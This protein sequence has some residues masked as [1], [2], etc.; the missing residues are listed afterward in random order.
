MKKLGKSLLI[1]MIGTSILLQSGCF[2]S[3]SL[4]KSVYDWNSSVDDKFTRSLLFW[5]LCIVPVYEIAA[6]VDAVI[7]NVVE[8]WTGSNP[9][10]MKDGER[11]EQ[12]VQVKGKSYR[13]VATKNKFLIEELGTVKSKRKVQLVFSPENRTWSV[14]KDGRAVALSG[15]E[16]QRNGEIAIRV[17][18]KD[19]NSRLHPAPE[20]NQQLEVFRNFA[21]ANAATANR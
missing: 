5:L 9:I 11:E 19:G 8:F 4:T 18:E 6:V 13:M 15:L 10:S 2:G 7:L 14:L 20:T 16:V 3:F 1:V 12:I 17:Y 21:M